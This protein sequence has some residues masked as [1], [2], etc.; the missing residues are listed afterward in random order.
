MQP[1]TNTILFSNDEK[2]F[3]QLNYMFCWFALEFLVF[4][5][6]GVFFFCTC[7]VLV[8]KNVAS[9]VKLLVVFYSQHIERGSCCH[10]QLNDVTDV[11]IKVPM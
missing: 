7:F 5:Y 11:T 9:K 8:T 6:G 3:V 4:F 10:V 1:M 2:R